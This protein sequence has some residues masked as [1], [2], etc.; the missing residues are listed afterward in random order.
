M[1]IA[2]PGNFAFR[3][4]SRVSYNH[5][6][7]HAY[8]SDDARREWQ[9]GP[10]LRGILRSFAA[11]LLV[12]RERWALWIPVLLGCGIGVYF[13][14]TV[15]PAGWVGPSAL[16]V[17]A[18]LAL[19]G[20][21][22][23][24][25][26]LPGIAALTVALGF[27]V[28][29]LDTWQVSAPV[30]QR[31]IGPV[32]IDGRIAEVDALPEDG[33]RIIL[34][35]RA[36]QRFDP[37]DLPSRV[38]VHVRRGGEDLQ[39]GEWISLRAIL[40]PPPAPAMPGAYDF[41]R[42]A[43]FDR[44]GA[45]GFAVS[46]VVEEPAPDGEGPPQWRLA[47]AALR[48]TITERITAA[49]PGA[50]GGI[51][52]AIITGETHAIP[53]A[54]AAAFRDAG[55]AHILV[56]AGLHMGMVAGLA[57]VGM[58]AFLALIPAVTLRYPTKKWAAAFALLVTFFYMLLSGATVSSRRSFI[59]TG[60]A[61]LA[62]L[63]D[64]L[65]LS[66]RGLAYAA[67]AIMLLTPLSVTGPSFQMSFA[68]VGGLIAFYETY[69]SR[70]A[71]WHREAG[72]VGRVALYVL[73]ICITT[74]VCTVAT[75][76]YT[77]FHF[78]RFAVFSVAAN[79]LAVPITGFWVMPWAMISCALM[80]LGLEAWGLTAMGWGID[81]IATI[82][83]DVTSWPG[84]VVVLPAMPLSCLLLVTCGGLWLIIWQR[85][86][87]LWGLAPICAG[88][89]GIAL[90]RPPDL[91]VAGDAKLIAAMAADG[92]Y[93]LSGKPQ[94]INVETWTRRAATGVTTPF[95][96]QGSSAD[97]MLSCDAIGC[98]YHARGRV[99]ALPREEQAIDEDCRNAD[100]VVS[101]APVRRRRC[102]AATQLIDRFDLWRGGAHAIWLDRDGI[103]I[104]TVEDWRGNRPWVPKRTP[105]PA[106][107]QRP[108]PPRSERQGVAFNTGARNPGG[109]N[110]DE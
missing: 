23:P 3:A 106:R 91:I 5:S 18:V 107:S 101:T 62:V 109:L 105:A 21:R 12:E 61:L 71:T 27:A 73:G 25:L 72:I 59:M 92:S 30:L 77:I 64:R 96:V 6:M 76:P 22:W 102:R 11:A 110:T 99:V 53:E 103:M 14:L 84:A 31:Q 36:I 55:L 63:V 97:G 80:P 8:R 95:P 43:F 4:T 10:A 13:S 81:L 51:A 93:M 54:D 68:A 79:I 9:L 82:A 20:R 75:A 46:P 41:Q 108:R 87:R 52:A 70:L 100:L 37:A 1:K 33:Q 48:N 65:P 69:R 42:R 89:V 19:L 26:L 60:L 58:R 49:L 98:L 66:A 29:Q 44:L 83:R 78:N 94:K 17:A 15:E 34:E 38:R 28:A 74:V 45:V 40:Y 56:I 2:H 104:E 90:V 24:P 7:H 85:P 57:F 16:L 47:V 50:G 39:P 88:L 32:R 35:P 86:W 67:T